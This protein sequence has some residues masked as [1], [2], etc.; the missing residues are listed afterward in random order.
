L[1][2]WVNTNKWSHPPWSIF[3]VRPR[4]TGNCRWGHIWRYK[5]GAVYRKYK[6]VH[7]HHD[8]MVYCQESLAT[9]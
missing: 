9:C 5:G 2:V 3:R 6:F 8:H 4:S 7:Q 1:R